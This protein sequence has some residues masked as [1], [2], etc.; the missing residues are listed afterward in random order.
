MSRTP[1]PRPAAA[2][3][4]PHP[5]LADVK[6]LIQD[7]AFSAT[8]EVNKARPGSGPDA[9]P[10]EP[11]RHDDLPPQLGAYRLVKP[12]GRGGM[13]MVFL[14]EDTHLHRQIALKVI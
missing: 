14:A 1:E 10:P 2:P 7:N 8:R 6:T 9:R 3:P 11:S 13:G 4:A 12:L 5:D